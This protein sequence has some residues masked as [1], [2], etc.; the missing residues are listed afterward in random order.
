MMNVKQIVSLILEEATKHLETPGNTS[1]DELN[2]SA[3]C[4]YLFLQDMCM[5]ANGEPGIW[6][7]GDACANPTNDTFALTC[8]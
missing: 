5:I 2:N 8:L 3:Q 6:M 7:K 1:P 4:V